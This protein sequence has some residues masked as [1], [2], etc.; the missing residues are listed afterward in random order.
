M[1]PVDA[2]LITLLVAILGSLAWLERERLAPVIAAARNIA[3]LDP[4]EDSR[5]GTL[6]RQAGL[7]SATAYR[8]CVAAK[9]VL[10]PGLPALAIAMGGRG[11]WVLVLSPIGVLLP[12]AVLRIRRRARQRAIRQQLSFFLD[13]ALSFLQAGLTIEDALARTARQGLPKNHPLA[14]E[15]L[16]VLDEISLGR[17]R[18]TGFLP[19]FPRT[20]VAELRGLAQALGSGLERG[21]SIEATLAAQA[22][23]ARARRREEGVKRIDA[24]K[25]EVLFPL[26]L[27]GFPMFVVLVFVPLALRVV[28]GLSQ[29]GQSVR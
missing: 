23:L 12:E 25:A 27:C 13:L 14:V 21:A 28:E 22:E 2:V 17:N 8:A 19:L 5:L 1:T 18:G 10:A 24:S 9:I 26:M 11:A 20:G 3:G 6:L 16:R 4:R 7:T 29:I 15:F